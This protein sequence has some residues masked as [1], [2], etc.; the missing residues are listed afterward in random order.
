VQKNRIGGKT[1]TLGYKLENEVI[2]FGTLTAKKTTA[3]FMKG[4]D[5]E[6]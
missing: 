2:K 1:G 5:A 6:D 4:W 3:P